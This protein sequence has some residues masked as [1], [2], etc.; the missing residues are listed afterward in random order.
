[1]RTSR[2][3]SRRA[4]LGGGGGGAAAAAGGSS[5]GGQYGAQPGYQAPPQQYG[6]PQPNYSIPQGPPAAPAA[7]EPP[8]AKLTLGS[9]GTSHTENSLANDADP[10]GGATEGSGTY[11][12]TADNPFGT[13]F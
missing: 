8:A 5:S 13:S 2:P 10:L 9:L 6:R 3:V 1:M 11:G 7:P 12:P 4:A